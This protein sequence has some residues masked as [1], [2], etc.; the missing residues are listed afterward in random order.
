MKHADEITAVIMPRWGMAMD[1]ATVVRWYVDVGSPVAAGTELVDIESDKATGAIEAKTLGTL[2]FKAASEGDVVPVGGLIGIIAAPD[3]GD[4]EISAFAAGFAP[5]RSG[6]AEDATRH[7]KIEVAGQ[8]MAF[9]E[10]GQGKE[11]V[12]LIHGF[13]G[14]A[15]SWSFNRQALALHF[16]VIAP[17]LPG[18]GDSEDAGVGTPEDLASAILGL[19]D[20]IGLHETHLIGHSMGG[21]AAIALAVAQHSRVRSLSILASTGLGLEINAK[22]ID[23]ILDAR[24][25][26]DLRRTMMDLFAD[27]SHIIDSM[28]DQVIRMKRI[29]GVENALRR[30]A[31]LH[32][33]GGRQA[34]ERLRPQFLSLSLPCQVIWGAEDKVIPVSH[35]MELPLAHVLPGAGH[36]LHMEQAAAINER[37]IA[38]VGAVSQPSSRGD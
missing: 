12:L 8:T 38:F 14:S 3:V 31:A 2:R 15:D 19:M 16:R 36:M 22:F 4:A 21:A 37:I 30:L 5:A 29:D 28:L 17:D 33:P 34:F 20:A 23:G 26:R 35:A 13:A 10:E 6:L 24:N 25:R 1:K 9:T 11:T 18:H 32:F 27:P 7:R